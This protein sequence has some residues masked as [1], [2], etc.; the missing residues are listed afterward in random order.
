MVVT[1]SPRPL[2]ILFKQ[3]LDGDV[4][5]LAAESNDAATGGG[6]RDLRFPD[7]PFRV[8]LDRFFPRVIT[9]S[10]N[11]GVVRSGRLVWHHN[12]KTDVYDVECWPPTDARPTEARIA[13]I[14]GLPPLLQCPEPHPGD[15]VFI[16]LT[17]DSTGDFR[18]DYARESELASR[19]RAEIASPICRSLL[20]ARSGRAACGWYLIPENVEY[21]HE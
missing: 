10:Q 21:I 12:S 3:M 20:L 16:I 9:V 17:L 6:A 1:A 4:R 2:A 14:H 13:K 15:P 5:K 19:W 18:S 8:V 7:A 11:G